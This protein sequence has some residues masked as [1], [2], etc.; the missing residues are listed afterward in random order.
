[1]Q[2]VLIKFWVGSFKYGLSILGLIIPKISSKYH[3]PLISNDWVKNLASIQATI[4]LHDW[5][6]DDSTFFNFTF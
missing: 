3:L 6:N 4:K 5:L 1:M 2:D